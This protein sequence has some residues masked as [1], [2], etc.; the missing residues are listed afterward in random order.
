[1][2]KI[3][4]ALMLSLFP[5]C[6][7]AGVFDADITVTTNGVSETKTFNFDDAGNFFNQLKDKGFKQS[8]KANGDFSG[9]NSNTSDVV[10]NT[11]FNGAP[12]SIEMSRN[13]TDLTLHAPGLPAEGH[14]FTGYSSRAASS[15]AMENYVRDDTDGVFS[16]ITEYQVGHS[17]TSPLQGNPNSLGGQMVAAGFNTAMDTPTSSGVGSSGSSARS[18]NGG[19]T[20]G[21]SSGNPF[22]VGV[23]GGTYNQNGTD[24]SIISVP[25]SKAFGISSADPRKK[26]LLNGQVNYVTVGKAASYQG[27]LGLAYM[28]PLKDNWFLIPSVNYGMI[29]SSDLASLGQIFSTSIASNYQFKTG[30]YD[31]ALINMFGYYKTLPFSLSGLVSSNPEINN[32][33]FKNG[34]FPSKV[35]SVLG[36]NIRTKGIFT[37]TEFLGSNV[38]IRQYNEVGVELSSVDKVKWL[39]KATFGMADALSFSAKYVFSIQDPNR[40]EGYDLGI[41]YDF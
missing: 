10:A 27:S 11:V 13:S 25:I 34:I 12:I 23:G 30:S 21:G 18:G 31:T 3:T 22:V 29:G 32:Y 2:K 39:S 28:H 9:Y 33:V 24:V 6:A 20:V 7:F 5:Y 1:M 15:K 8:F 17:A 16:K 37:D 40:F 14:K 38:F 41:S 36:H 26:L 35:W 19:K 4:T